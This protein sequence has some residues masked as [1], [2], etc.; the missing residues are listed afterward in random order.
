MLDTCMGSA[1]T[2]VVALQNNRRFLGIELDNNY[3]KI[4]KKRLEDLVNED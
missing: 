3:F 1:S 4:C 2:G